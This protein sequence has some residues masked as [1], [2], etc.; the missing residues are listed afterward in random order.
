MT[1]P[2]P[3]F[4][5]NKSLQYL[6]GKGVAK[7]PGKAF[8]LN[9]ESADLGYGDAVL[10]MG[11]FYLNGV[12]VAQDLDQ[13]DRWYRRSARQGDPRAMFSLGQMAYGAREFK[14]ALAWFTRASDG[15]HARSLFWIGKLHW[16]GRGVSKDKKQAMVLFQK[17]SR[18]KVPEAQRALRLLSKW[19][20][21]NNQMQQT[22]SAAARRRG[23]R[24]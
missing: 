8:L 24:C 9:T 5:Y 14:S 10:A 1:V 2:G 18:R 16:H 3:T 12:G 20:R 21:S 6:D 13:A 15:G 22:R 17:A 23:P 19:G 11:W 4:L 7:N